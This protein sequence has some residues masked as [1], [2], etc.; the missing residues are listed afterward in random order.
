M[1][2]FGFF[3]KKLLVF[4]FNIS[5]HENS[6]FCI[7]TNVHFETAFMKIDFQKLLC[8]LMSILVLRYLFVNKPA[9][10]LHVNL[11]SFY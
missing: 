2:H 6:I 8:S 10:N 7:K 3:F 11:F 4:Y 9:L 5:F 1:K